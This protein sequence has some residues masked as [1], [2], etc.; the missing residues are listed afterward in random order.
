MI[1]NRQIG[2]DVAS[3]AVIRLSRDHPM[4]FHAYM[5]LVTLLLPGLFCVS[6][7]ISPLGVEPLFA[8]LYEPLSI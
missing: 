6:S 7:S 5:N 4:A 8:P 1:L 2:H 3:N